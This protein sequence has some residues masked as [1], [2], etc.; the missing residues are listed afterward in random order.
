M[1]HARLAIVFH[2]QVHHRHLRDHGPRGGGDH[3]DYGPSARLADP[4]MP[5]PKAL[6]LPRV[7]DLEIVARVRSQV[8]VRSACA[9]RL[10]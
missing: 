8:E 1:T 4:P 6:L 9:D 5:S 2:C 7:E 10:F 3:G